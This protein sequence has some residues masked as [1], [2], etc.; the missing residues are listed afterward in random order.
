MNRESE[1]WQM[2]T[3]KDRTGGARKISDELGAWRSIAAVG[4]KTLTQDGVRGRFDRQDGITL[5][6][7]LL[8]LL[9]FPWCDLIDKLKVKQGGGGENKQVR[10]GM[11]TSHYFMVLEF[12]LI[13]FCL[14]SRTRMQRLLYI[15]IF[16]YL[17]RGLYISSFI[18]LHPFLS[19]EET[20]GYSL[21]TLFCGLCSLHLCFRP[22]I[23]LWRRHGEEMEQHA[24]EKNAERGSS[25]KTV[26]KNKPLLQEINNKKEWHA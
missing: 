21:K 6:V 8:L 2:G 5:H 9:F 7:G 14:Y 19:L 24:E 13:A 25:S 11:C 4:D 12:V 1:K 22:I 3:K 16:I 23:V 17:F 15:Y 20:K 10:K 26:F 18:F